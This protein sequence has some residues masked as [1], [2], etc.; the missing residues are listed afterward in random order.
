LLVYTGFLFPDLDG[1]CS[2]LNPTHA[3]NPR[4]I[5]LRAKVRMDD[6]EHGADVAVHHYSSRLL[7]SMFGQWVSYV[8]ETKALEEE[9][10]RTALHYY[11]PAVLESAMFR[12]KWI[13]FVMNKQRY[14]S[15]LAAIGRSFILQKRGLCFLQKRVRKMRSGKPMP[16][17]SCS[18]AQ[19][20]TRMGMHRFFKRWKSKADTASIIGRALRGAISTWTDASPVTVSRTL[21]VQG[22]FKQ[23]KVYTAG[24]TESSKAY[25]SGK[26][27]F[28]RQ[29][30]KRYLGKLLFARKPKYVS[31]SE[32]RCYL[33]HQDGSPACRE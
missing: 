5:A 29:L 33:I 10:E 16:G 3:Q 27:W 13:H 24:V 6:M 9:A 17:H 32:P 23:W 4:G 18:N 12:L 25:E 8:A 22:Q 31:L 26:R 30:K 19:E 21:L 1:H 2:N 28:L 20:V 14:N 7:S 15:I 11:R